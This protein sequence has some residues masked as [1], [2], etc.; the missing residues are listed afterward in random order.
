[1]I[2]KCT[3]QDADIWCQLNQE[4]MAYE[5][6]DENVWENPL[7]KGD[8]KDIFYKII[9]ER[10]SPN[11]LFVIEEENEIIGFMNLAYFTSIWARGKVLFLDDFFITESKRN[12]GYGKKALRDLEALS[13]REGFKRIQLLAEK[14][15]PGA[16][17]FYQVEN[18]SEQDI[19]LFCKYL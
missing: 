19:H 5:Y 12:K 7:E 14:T 3:R 2:R 10:H 8:P 4:F 16:V 13:K 6:E 9:E 18:Y 1:M 11:I 15:N 17:N